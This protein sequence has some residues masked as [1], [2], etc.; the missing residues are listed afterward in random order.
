[1]SPT[2]TE[3][4]TRP[5]KPRSGVLSR[6]LATGFAAISVVALAMCV[7]LEAL[8]GTV[9]GSV[10]EMQSGEATVREGLALATA[11]REQ[12]NHQARMLIE[13]SEKHVAHN[14]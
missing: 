9:E 12:Y 14:C 10:E 5:T 11:V 2:V 6:R 13:Q 3:S 1:M 4:D 7:V 8:L